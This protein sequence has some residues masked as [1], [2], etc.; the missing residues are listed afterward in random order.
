M[1]SLSDVKYRNISKEP[2]WIYYFI[3][4]SFL[5]NHIQWLA[6]STVS[7]ISLIMLILF[8]FGNPI[9]DNHFLIL[10]PTNPLHPTSMEKWSAIHPASSHSF[11][12]SEYRL[13]FLSFAASMLSS[14]GTVNSTRCKTFASVHHK[15]ISGFFD[16]GIG[17]TFLQSSKSA[18]TSQTYC[19]WRFGG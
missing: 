8:V 1:S 16:V 11:N 3:H 4:S 13:S 2:L 12:N 19:V 14:C 9:T 5:F 17:K 6:F 15:K 7:W 18:E 10:F